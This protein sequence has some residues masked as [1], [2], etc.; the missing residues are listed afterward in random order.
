MS[1]IGGVVGCT[2]VA[3]NYLAYARVL[4]AG[5]RRHH[6]SR[7]FHVLVIDEPRGADV[8]EGVRVLAAEELGLS[9]AEL[10]QLRGIYGVAELST[11]LK[12]HLLRTLLGR[13]ADVAI[14]LDA[15]TEV[16]A[17]L[18][19]VGGLAERYGVVL[20]T[21]FL[22]PPPFDGRSPTEPE[23]AWSGLFN[24]GFLAVSGS[25]LP[26]IDWWASRLRRD[27][28]FC[29]SAG[30]HA[31]QKWL[32]FVPSYFEHHVLRDRGINV[33]Q[34][35]VHERRVEFE[36]GAFTAGG[37]PLRTFHFSG[38]DPD[39]ASRPGPDE[40]ANPLRFHMSGE[41][42]LERLCRE[43]GA[44][45][46]AAGHRE[47]REVPYVYGST[48]SGRPLG[49][50][51]RHAYREMLIAAEC[52]GGVEIPD[53]FDLE[54]AAEFERI[55]DDPGGTGLLSGAARG[56]LKD[57][58]LA[59]PFARGDRMDQ[60]RLAVGLLRQIPRRIPG[61]RVPWMPHPLTSDRTRMEYDIGNLTT[62]IRQGGL[63]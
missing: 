49:V 14:F 59:G 23:I 8:G 35:N 48:A 7:P 2:I 38:F 55:L 33:A 3:V 4:A 22:E 34:W 11:A 51:E 56:R 6:G 39:T 10:A 60:A 26:F 41:P 19:H 20:S 25:S 9:T 47:L 30:M 52:R 54:R 50:W 28:L 46:F 24:S 21:H 43:Y 63:A 15:D 5:W 53:P 13:G 44:K 27:C 37:V 31:D 40:W 45:L 57:A 58:R 42:A 61:R 17:G 16:H 29:E 36:E 62:A 32:D 1:A 12:P 18:E